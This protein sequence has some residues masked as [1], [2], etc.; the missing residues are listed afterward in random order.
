MLLIVFSSVSIIGGL[1]FLGLL[2]IIGPGRRDSSGF[3][4]IAFGSA[5]ILLAC[6]WC[7]STIEFRVDRR[8]RT[9][10]RRLRWGAW[11]FPSRRTW[12]DVSRLLIRREM[13]LGV[14]GGIRWKFV[15][16]LRPFGRIDRK[17]LVIDEAA[18]KVVIFRISSFSG[19]PLE[20]TELFNR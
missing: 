11:P 6:V 19:L 7:F 8:S 1:T 10:V 4:A 20:G 3:A 18:A 16:L 14:G 15:L 2:P 17:L 9:F 13:G 5:F 12:A